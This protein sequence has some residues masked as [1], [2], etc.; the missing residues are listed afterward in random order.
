MTLSRADTRKL[1]KYFTARPV[2]RAFLF[3]S[4][5]RNTAIKGTSDIDILVELD[6]STPIGMKFFAYQPELEQ[7]LHTK[8][9]LITT[10]GLSPIVKP[11]IDKDKIL[12]Y[13]RKP[14][15]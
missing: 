11:Y 9:D 3:G 2:K 4:Y 14:R 6:H 13:E 12:I 15:G 5:S 8:V 7:L 1:Q 10:D